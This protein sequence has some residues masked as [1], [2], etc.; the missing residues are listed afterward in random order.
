M[1][2]HLEKA[3]LLNAAFLFGLTARLLRTLPKFIRTNFPAMNNDKLF[4]L[5]LHP[6]Y[7]A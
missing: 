1:V 6:C 2:F 7:G 4:L 3:V 5:S